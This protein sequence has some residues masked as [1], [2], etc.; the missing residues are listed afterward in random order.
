MRKKVIVM[1]A[2]IFI[3]LVIAV[4][5]LAEE[6]GYVFKVKSDV[7]MLYSENEKVNSH[8]DNMYSADSLEDIYEFVPKNMIEYIIPNIQLELYSNDYPMVTSDTL[9]SEQWNLQKIY[10]D[11]AREKGLSGKGVKIGLIDSGV[12]ASHPDI[13]SSK[14]ITGFNCMNDDDDTNDYD[15]SDVY[16]HGTGVCAIISAKTDNESYLAGIAPNASIIPIKIT[17]TGSFDLSVLL[18]AIETAIYYDCDIINMSL[19]GNIT[20]KTI[21]NAIKEKIDKAANAGIIIIAAVGNENSTATS[22]PAGFDNVIGVGSVKKDLSHSKYSQR[23]ESVFIS[24]PGHDV[25]TLK[26]GG[27]TSTET[28]TSFATP[29]I[30][31]VC[32]LIKEVLP[33]ATL[34]DIKE[35]LKASTDDLGD[36]GYDTSFG[37]GL[38][39]VRKVVEQLEPHL[40]QLVISEGIKN[41]IPRIHI[42]NNGAE[43]KN[44]FAYFANESTSGN[45]EDIFLAKKDIDENKVT[46]I[47]PNM[48]FNRFFWWDENMKPY[49]KKIVIE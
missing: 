41:G 15:T 21:I 20:N 24:A 27:Q 1:I 31:A 16:G 2:F 9:Y 39:N 32:A 48:N 47:S 6:N 33:D 36:E 17:N 40:P 14:I 38:I 7:V 45:Q 42:H 3:T 46:T 22:Y 11:V 10:A 5:S 18:D 29:H 13:D 37:Y 12:D 34:S 35:I 30:T 26:I 19:G 4:P 49:I 8:G 28:G 44:T 43:I 23:N 25:T